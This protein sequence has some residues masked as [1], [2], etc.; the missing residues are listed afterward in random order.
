MVP[1]ML[2]KYKNAF[3]M[4]W[5]KPEYVF[6]DMEDNDIELTEFDKKRIEN[7][8]K[9]IFDTACLWCNRG[10]SKPNMLNII[11]PNDGMQDPDELDVF[12]AL[13]DKAGISFDGLD[14]FDGLNGLD[15]PDDLDD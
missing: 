8:F 3:H 9:Q 4:G 7:L 6:K 11:S 15:E 1:R 5:A 12:K 14:G 2:E 13:F 10:L